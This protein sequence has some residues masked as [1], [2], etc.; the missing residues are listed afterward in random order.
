MMGIKIVKTFLKLTVLYFCTTDCAFSQAYYI[1]VDSNSNDS[2]SDFYIKHDKKL[3]TST[4]ICIGKVLSIRDTSR[5]LL[6]EFMNIPKVSE[7]IK[8]T[9]IRN[10]RYEIITIMLTNPSTYNIHK[11]DSII[12]VWIHSDSHLRLV[13]EENLHYYFELTKTDSDKYVVNSNLLIE[14]YDPNRLWYYE[15][16]IQ[17]YN[18]DLKNGYYTE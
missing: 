14:L 6:D 12:N 4:A 11:K 18:D 5:K 17:K 1:S 2:T 3:L 10:N 9:I 8:N 13:F 15:K 7:N 16:M